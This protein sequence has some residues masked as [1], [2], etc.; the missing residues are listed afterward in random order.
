MSNPC[1]GLTYTCNETI[2]WTLGGTGNGSLTQTR[3]AHATLKLGTTLITV[4]SVRRNFVIA[5]NSSWTANATSVMLNEDGDPFA[6][7]DNFTSGS[8]PHNVVEDYECT[9]TV[10]Y[11]LD[12]RYNNAIF[13]EVIEKL[14]FSYSGSDMA[15]FLG[16]Y[17]ITWFPKFVIT[18][19]NIITT[20][21]YY[22]VL[23]GRTNVLKT[24]T[25]TSSIYGPGNPLILVWPNPPSNYTPWIG[26][27]DIKQFGFYDYHA[28]N[29]DQ[30]IP[31]GGDDFYFTEWM[32]NIGTL[33]IVQDQVDAATRYSDY[34]LGE[35]AF[36]TIPFPNPGIITDSTPVGSIVQ[37]PEGNIFYSLELD[38]EIFN[39]LSSP[40]AT[41]ISPRVLAD[42]PTLFPTLGPRQKYFPVGLI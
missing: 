25:S 39:S 35:G 19:C 40:G 13:K 3:D 16:P 33:S 36:G 8:T 42:L 32:R 30:I 18:N 15:G 10:F 6:C 29:E 4:S 5:E 23:N 41:D 11:F 7:P 24:S 27:D 31:D 9:N 17:G 14:T 22:I 37:D 34:Y 20:I 12:T 38:G 28:S 21:N 1:E 26:C 2:P